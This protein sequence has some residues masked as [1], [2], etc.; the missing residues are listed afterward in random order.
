MAVEGIV[1]SGGMGESEM[2][3][4]KREQFHLL[5]PSICVI[6]NVCL[7]KFSSSGHQFAFISK[8]NE[9]VWTAC[10]LVN[11]LVNLAQAVSERLE[12]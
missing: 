11:C 5:R 1:R 4:E 9:F 3:S 7:S 12:C 2:G 8:A 6:C 10:E